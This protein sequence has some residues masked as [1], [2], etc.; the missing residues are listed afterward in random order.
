MAPDM[1][2]ISKK[3]PPFNVCLCCPHTPTKISIQRNLNYGEQK[4]DIHLSCGQDGC[5]AGTSMK[6]G[7]DSEEES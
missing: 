4:A 2:S 6:G 5:E 7:G 3:R 1:E